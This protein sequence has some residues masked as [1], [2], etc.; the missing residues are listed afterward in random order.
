MNRI[1]QKYLP[2]KT[3]PDSGLPTPTW[4]IVPGNPG[5]APAVRVGVFD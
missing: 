1:F 5:A 2:V 3:F 4:M